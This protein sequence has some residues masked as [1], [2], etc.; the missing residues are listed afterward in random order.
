MKRLLTTVLLLGVLSTDGAHLTLAADLPGTGPAAIETAALDSLQGQAIDISPWAYAWRADLAVQERPEACFIPRRLERIDK[1]YRTALDELGAAALKS[2]YYDMPDLLTPLPPK[3]RGRLLAGLLWSVRLA[4]YRVE[5]CWPD[6][7]EVP[8]L[9]AVE[10]RVYPT[11]FGWFGWCNDEILGQPEISADRR[12]WTYNHT[13]VAEIPTVIG[14]THRRG[15]ATEMV[16]VFCDDEKTPA[17][18]PC[19]VPVIRL[20]SPTIGTWKRMDVEI[21][22][23]FQP[24]S[25]EAGFDGRLES[26]LSLIGQVSPLADDTGTTVTG[27]HAWQSSAEAGVRRGIALPLLYVPSDRRALDTPTV[28][29][30][31]L[32]DTTAPGPPVPGPTL[33][34]RVTLWTRTGGLTFRPLDLE[35]GPILIPEHGIFV[36]KAGSGVTARQFAADLAAKNL[37]SVR[38]LT[39]EHREAVSWDELMREVRLWRCPEEPAVPP[40]PAVEDPPMQVQLSDARWT[41]AWRAA[42]HQLRGQHMWGGLAFEVGRVARQ[43]DMVALHDEADKVYHHFLEAPGAKPDGDY[44]DG[45]GALEL[46]TSMRHDMGYSH[47]GTHASTGRLLFGMAERYFLTGDKEWFGRHRDRLQAAADW[48]IR[49]RNSYMKDVPNR[50]DLLV[51]GLMPPYMLGDYALPACDWRWYYCDNAFSLQGLQRFADALA[52]FDPEAGQKYRAEAETFRRDIRR[53]VDREAALSPVRLGRDGLYHSFVPI[54]A[55]TRGL[56]LALEFPSVGR[57]QGDVIIGALPLAEPF[58]ALEANDPRMIGTLD[59]MEE[60]GTSADA[61][62]Q[63]EEARKTKGLSTA[64][65]WFWNCYGASLP[66]ASH[67]ANIYLLQDDVP[68]F[69]RF[70][71]NSYA[72]MVGTD[73]KMWEWGQWGQFTECTAPD[74][75]TAGWFL[76]NF[77]NLLVMEEGQTLWLARATPRVWLEPGKTISVRNAPTYFG[78]VAYEIVSHGDGGK[79]T[80][81]VEMPSRNPPQTVMLRFRHPQAKPIKSVTLNGQDWQEYN[82]DKEVI[83]LTGV[84]GTAT[85]V[86]NY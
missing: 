40:F 13:G 29:A 23:G 26:D 20:I 11:A 28:T 44:A 82:R 85:I 46:A 57:P 31:V 74:N 77:R 8:S 17:G 67:N 58:A 42:S 15:S 59:I 64:D 54:A 70:W 47:D 65:A 14:R 33:D 48:I 37:K 1:V 19:P 34:S 2:L 72:I 39:R 4:D 41:E 79:I 35:K 36:T 86:A 66:K 71:M 43:M 73:G 22:W 21:E 69:L 84:Q 68:N 18:G 62:R 60:V 6:G 5:L 3:P 78:T 76:E 32:F 25:E 55:Y 38:Q 45:N 81:T 53:A 80:A 63:L 27:P 50:G 56:M 52:Q 9:D 10:V 61:I 16:A 75:G 12:T 30:S 83:L 24:G 51:A 49:Q 7:Q